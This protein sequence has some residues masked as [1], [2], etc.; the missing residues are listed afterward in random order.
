MMHKCGSIG[1]GLLEQL[2]TNSQWATSLFYL[3]FLQ[4]FR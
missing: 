1:L 2:L 3:D 4:A